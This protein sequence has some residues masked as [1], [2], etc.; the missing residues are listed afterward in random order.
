MKTERAFGA[1]KP[2][3]ISGCS[4]VRKIVKEIERGKEKKKKQGQVKP[5]AF[6][7]SDG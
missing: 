2:S 6:S 3:Q 5:P 7:G 4:S 1:H